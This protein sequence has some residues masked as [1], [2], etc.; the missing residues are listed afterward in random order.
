MIQV[1]LVSHILARTINFW[2]SLIKFEIIPS[3]IKLLV[4]NEMQ[5]LF[6]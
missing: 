2:T 3:C 6:S 5:S 1:N 4:I